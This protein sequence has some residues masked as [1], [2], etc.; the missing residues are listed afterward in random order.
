MI[1]TDTVVEEWKT[2][3]RFVFALVM[4]ILCSFFLLCGIIPA[5]FRCVW[6]YQDETETVTNSLSKDA[7]AQLDIPK[8]NSVDEVIY[9][10]SRANIQTMSDL[11]GNSVEIPR[12]SK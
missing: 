6:S 7:Y 12:E 4:L 11:S 3:T 10:V 9:P 8:V 2:Q 5:C 1:Q